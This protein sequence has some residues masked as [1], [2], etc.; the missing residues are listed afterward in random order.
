ME[1]AIK[2]A[3]LAKERGNLP[4]GSV[5]VQGNKIVAKGFSKEIEN[6]NATFHAEL[7]AISQACQKL[8]NNELK[9]CEIYASGEPCTM[10]ASAIFQAKIPK[11]FIA[12]SR[13]DLPHI[14]RHREINIFSLAKDSSYKPMISTGLLKQKS[15][16]LFA[17]IK[18]L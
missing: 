12:A 11:I 6:H 4:F 16:D 8:G 2:Q 7:Q 10:C 9:D 3:V 14:F 1:E 17:D 13:N 18:L 5:I 15:I